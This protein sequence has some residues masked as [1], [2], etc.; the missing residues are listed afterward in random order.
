MYRDQINALK[1]MQARQ[2]VAGRQADI[3]FIA[4]AQEQGSSCVQ[5]VSIRGGRNLGQR[6]YFP[7]QAEGRGTANTG[8][9]ACDQRDLV[10]ESMHRVFLAR[11]GE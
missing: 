7:S 6:S 8:G 5:V 11:C 3:D 10:V 4:L 2:F 1:Q 9:R